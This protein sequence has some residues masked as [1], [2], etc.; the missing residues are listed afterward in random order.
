MVERYKDHLIVA[1]A[2][3]DNSGNYVSLASVSWQNEDGTRG[4]HVIQ[5]SDRYDNS[6]SAMHFAIAAA[7]NWIDDRLKNL[8]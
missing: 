5:N 2:T 8:T 6:P 7:K 4:L 3:R 1:S